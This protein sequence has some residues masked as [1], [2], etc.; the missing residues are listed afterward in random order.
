MRQLCEV[1]VAGGI[2]GGK[3][4]FPLLTRC[5]MQKSFVQNKRLLK[6]QMYSEDVSNSYLNLLL[7]PSCQSL[8]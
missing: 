6:I 4:C 3:I 7:V 2:G 8:L 5:E 1:G